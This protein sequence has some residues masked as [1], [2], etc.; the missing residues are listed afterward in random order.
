M[1]TKHRLGPF[2]FHGIWGQVEGPQGRTITITRAGLNGIDLWRIGIW[3]EPFRLST[4]MFC[5]S[6]PEAMALLRQYRRL[7]IADPQP[8]MIAGDTVPGTRFAVLAVRDAASEAI[9]RCKVAR[10]PRWYRA[11][12][13]VEWNLQ[14]I[15]LI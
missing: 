1:A 4:K 9:L 12:C 13:S 10:D 5:E 11:V 7:T 3:A 6:Y 2:S 8:L 15:A 14:P